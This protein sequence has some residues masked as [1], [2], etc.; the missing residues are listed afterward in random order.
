[1]PLPAR[2]SRS[3]KQL[4]QTQSLGPLRIWD[5]ACVTSQCARLDGMLVCC[6]INPLHIMPLH[7][8][9]NNGTEVLDAN[10]LIEG[11]IIKAVGRVPPSVTG[12]YEELKVIDLKGA[13]VTPGSKYHCRCA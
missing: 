10:I 5:E 13:W 3:A 7:Q 12:P 11:G 6:S 4:L 1:M 2:H 9:G 8:G